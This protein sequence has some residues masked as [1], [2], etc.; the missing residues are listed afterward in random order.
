MERVLH[1]IPTPI[2][3]LADI[4]LRALDI[5][6]NSDAILVEDSRVTGK[7]LKHYN[8]KSKMIRYH[9]FNEHKKIKKIMD[10]IELGKRISLVSDAGTPSISDPGFLLIRECIRNNVQIICLPGATACIPALVTSG[11][12]C[13]KF[14]FE[15][16][17]PKKK[18]RRKILLNIMSHLKTTIIYE[19]PHRIL[20]T[21]AEMK[22]I[23]ENRNVV[24][25]K[26]LTKLNEAVYRGT[27]STVI[28]LINKSKLKG[29]FVI[30]LDGKK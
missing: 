17:L 9:S 10:E 3:N 7:L 26:E 8:I 1:I 30:I 16:F 29:E 6:K 2:G 12:P 27:I 22:E 14:I 19:S 18:G 11:L 4:T 21:L 25:I 24:V 23:C 13:E 5:L 28:D 15:G 20:K